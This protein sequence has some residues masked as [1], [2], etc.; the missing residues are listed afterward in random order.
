MVEE[1]SI[2]GEDSVRDYHDVWWSD[3]FKHIFV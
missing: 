2:L 3:A 1:D